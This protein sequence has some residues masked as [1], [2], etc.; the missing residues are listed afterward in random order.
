MAS[1]SDDGGQVGEPLPKPQEQQEDEQQDPQQQEVLKSEP[2]QL[3]A[4]PGSAAAYSIGGK[5]LSIS[6]YQSD[7]EKLERDASVSL[8]ESLVEG[9][10]EEDDDE[11][12]IS[13]SSASENE[14]DDDEQ[15]NFDVTVDVTASPEVSS[16]GAMEATEETDLPSQNDLHNRTTKS[17]DNHGSP[18]RERIDG[19]AFRINLETMMELHGGQDGLMSYIRDIEDRNRQL[20]L[21]LANERSEKLLQNSVKESPA[22]GSPLTLKT[23]KAKHYLLFKHS[24]ES[25]AWV[26][27]PLSEEMQRKIKF[28]IASSGSAKKKKMNKKK[29]KKTEQQRGAVPFQVPEVIVKDPIAEILDIERR[30]GITGDIDE[31]SNARG[32]RGQEDERSSPRLLSPTKPQA[33]QEKKVNVLPEL[34][35]VTK[36]RLQRGYI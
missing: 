23:A 6:M 8:S 15:G 19:S 5:R 4:Q 31:E 24:V 35:V 33:K 16:H 36:W 18:V 14:L 30:R 1:S 22:V 9:E 13:S 26:E 17:R 29:K 28:A 27:Q 3:V 21:D 10:G 11:T 7:L 32:G 34:D 12:T 25:N 20:L 2:G